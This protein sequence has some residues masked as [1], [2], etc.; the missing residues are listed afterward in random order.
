MIGGVRGNH[1]TLTSVSTWTIA[2]AEFILIML[3]DLVINLHISQVQRN[4]TQNNIYSITIWIFQV[5]P[6]IPISN[7]VT[8]LSQSAHISNLPA[9]AT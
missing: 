5:N 9:T 7:Q 2:N 3:I 1:N 8:F 4:A 6:G